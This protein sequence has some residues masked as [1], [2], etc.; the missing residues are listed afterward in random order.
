LRRLTCRRSTE[1]SM[2]RTRA[3]TRPNMTIWIFQ[4]SD[5]RQVLALG[6]TPAGLESGPWLNAPWGVA[7]APPNFGIYS[8]HL[9]IGN[10]G[11]GQ[12]RR[13]RRCQWPIRR[14]PA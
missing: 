8:N 5:C 11:S 14:A 7:L 13:L 6:Q 4:A 2:L 1:I 12:N 9:L 10:A 3:K